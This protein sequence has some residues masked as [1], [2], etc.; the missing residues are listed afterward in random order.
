MAEYT[1]MGTEF[2]DKAG[3]EASILLVKIMVDVAYFYSGQE[4][5][6]VSLFIIA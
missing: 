1:E 3:Y 4:M 2:G 5:L 6:F